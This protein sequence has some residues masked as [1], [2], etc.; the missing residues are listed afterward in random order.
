MRQ[1]LWLVAAAAVLALVLALS[2]ILIPWKSRPAP[3]A[4]AL[5]PSQLTAN[6]LDNA[7]RRAAISPDGKY[8]PY[9]DLPGLHVL[10]LDPG[11]TRSSPWPEKLCPR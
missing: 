3:E 11:E 10:E 7:V 1:H 9:A 6:P 5:L 4:L 2:I 8:L